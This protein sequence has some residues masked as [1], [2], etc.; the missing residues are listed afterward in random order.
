MEISSGIF[1]HLLPGA[2]AKNATAG[3]LAGIEPAA[4]RFRCSTLSNGDR[5]RQPSSSNHKFINTRVVPMDGAHCHHL[6]SYCI[7]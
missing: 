7:C 6:V 2:V 5:E 3:P 4:L 1:I